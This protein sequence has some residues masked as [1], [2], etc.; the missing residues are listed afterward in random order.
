[1]KLLTHNL[2]LCN[3]KSCINQGVNNFPLRLT[4]TKWEDYDDEAAIECTMALMTRLAE[5]LEWA[6]L[7]DTVATVSF[8][9]R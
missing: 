2:L 8:Y 5:K 9:T 7:R 3:R 1:M 4:V 6:A